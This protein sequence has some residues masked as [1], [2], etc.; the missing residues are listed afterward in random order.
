MIDLCRKL[1]DQQ[2]GGCQHTQKF[3]EI[4]SHESWGDVLEHQAGPYKIERVASESPKVWSPV[5]LELTASGRAVVSARLG[6]HRLGNVDADDSLKMWCKRLGETSYAAAEVEDQ[7]SLE[8]WG[9]AFDICHEPCDV[10]AASLEE[11]LDVPTPFT[12]RLREDRRQCIAPPE[13]ISI[14]SK[15]SHRA[16]PSSAHPQQDLDTARDDIAALVRHAVQVS[17]G[18]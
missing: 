2:A 18:G 16:H 4:A 7:S 5:D 1:K 15:H 11:L 9:K 13:G 12:G 14:A 10:R 17:K 6:D 8:G 3:P